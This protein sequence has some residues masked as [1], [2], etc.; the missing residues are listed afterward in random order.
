MKNKIIFVH[1]FNN[2]S[3]SPKVLEDVINIISKDHNCLLVTNN[4]S[5][6]LDNL[7][8][9]K[10]KFKFELS[11]NKIVTLKN[12]FLA[13]FNIF[14]ILSK[15]INKGDIVYINTTIPIFAGFAAKVKK[16]KVIF[17]LHEFRKSLN[18]VHRFLSS[19]RVLVCD[20][21]IF[22]SNYLKKIEHIEGIE[23]SVVHNTLSNKFLDLIEANVH[24]KR[25][26]F[27]VLMICSLKKY[28]GIYEFIKISKLLE[29][30]ESITFSL[31]L[32]EDDQIVNDFFND[33]EIP[34][35]MNV[36]SKTRDTASYYRK[37]SILLNLSR[38]DEWIETFGLTI[39]EGMAY[40]LPCIVPNVGGPSEL[41]FNNV[42]GYRIS[43]YETL[44][45][46]NLIS[47]L[48][49][50]V[51]LYNNMSTESKNLSKNFSFN[52]FQ[53]QIKSI[54]LNIKDSTKI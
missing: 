36:Y 40:G 39:L 18:I 30:N 37:A 13:Q 17:H 20:Y 35:N 33:I 38:P 28:K 26:G 15:N 8:V 45:I 27:N 32:G 2:F 31:V 51:K 24:K 41:V 6:F 50:D 29:S 53:K 47:K 54:I 5:G 49:K 14:M 21:E 23:S 43:C 11:S 52:E 12:Y 10:I 25:D 48:Q 9:Q 19:F 44:K 7:S 46:S 4:T 34:S 3:G 22:V 1:F 42:N 16:A